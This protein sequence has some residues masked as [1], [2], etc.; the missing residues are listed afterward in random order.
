MEPTPKSPRVDSFLT[1]IGMDRKAALNQLRCLAPPIGCGRMIDPAELP[2]WP[3][4]AQT[5]YRISG[6][7]WGCQRKAFAD[8]DDPRD[9]AEICTCDTPCCQADVGIGVID[10]GFLHCAVHGRPSDESE[11]DYS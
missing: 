8:P 4:N 9:P 6:W 7:C 11:E 1:A 10:C 2:T 3:S 5:E